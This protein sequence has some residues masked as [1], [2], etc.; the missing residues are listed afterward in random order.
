[1]NH[2]VPDPLVPPLLTLLALATALPGRTDAQDLSL[3]LV[4]TGEA[5]RVARGGLRT[6][7]AWLGNVD[8]VLEARELGSRGTSALLYVLG[9]HGNPLSS[10]VGDA[11]VTSNIEAPEAVRIFEAWVE[12]DIPDAGLSFL[13]GLYDLNSEFD[14]IEAA[15]LLLNSSFGIG[16]DYAQSGVAGPSIFP[17]SSLAARAIWR[18]DPSWYVQTAV[19][20]GVPGD[21]ADETAT[22]IHLSTEDGALLAAEAGWRFGGRPAAAAVGRFFEAEG[23]TRMAVGAWYYTRDFEPLLPPGG[24]GEGGPRRTRPGVYALAEGVIRA[25]EDAGPGLSVFARAG[26][27]DPDFHQFGSYTGAGAV[28]TGLLPA[29]P[30]DR[31]GLGVAAAHNGSPYRSLARET[32]PGATPRET[33]FELTY[34]LRGPFW[35]LQ[36]DLQWVLHPGTDPAVD[37]ALLLG[38]RGE[39]SVVF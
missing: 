8:A 7:T 27:S 15:G 28:L 2:P 13:L 26:W 11:Q 19:L 31:L 35:A 38:I 16:P 25:E 6:G 3:E 4:Y 10:W 22:A 37:H 32:G 33:V 34:R 29:R 5:V 18:P 17:L 36:P 30:E 20:D 21:P 39:I 14:V 23:V 9:S 12:H 24:A 1:M